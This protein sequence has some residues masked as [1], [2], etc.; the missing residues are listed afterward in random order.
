MIEELT[1]EPAERSRASDGKLG[2][3]HCQGS[4]L[5][6]LIRGRL[7]LNHVS[8]LDSETSEPSVEN[9]VET[10]VRNKRAGISTG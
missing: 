7:Y 1:Q 3:P 6:I 2:M 4:S 10:I 8:C 9:Q 5:S